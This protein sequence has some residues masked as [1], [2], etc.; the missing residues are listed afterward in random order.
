MKENKWKIIIILCVVLV[1]LLFIIPLGVSA[2]IYEDNFGNRYEKYAPMARNIDEFE[3]L[4]S[5]R[6]AFCL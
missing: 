2:L 1:V 5:H 3:G 6:Y 4:N